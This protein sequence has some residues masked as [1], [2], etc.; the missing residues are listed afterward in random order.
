MFFSLYN[1]AIWMEGHYIR[2]LRRCKN[3]YVASSDNVAFIDHLS[4]SYSEYRTGR[5]GYDFI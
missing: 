1:L 2:T 3:R 4:M 5:R